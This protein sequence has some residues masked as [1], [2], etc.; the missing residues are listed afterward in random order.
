MRSTLERKLTLGYL[1]SLKK[2]Y[3]KGKKVKMRHTYGQGL[4]FW[5]D[6]N[7]DNGFILGFYEEDLASFLASNIQSGSVF[8]DLGAHWGYFSLLASKLVGDK[9]RVYAFEP[10]PRNFR[11]LQKNLEINSTQQIELFNLAV[12]EKIGK[13]RFSNTDD[14]FANT[15]V[16]N[17]SGNLLEICAINLD[18]FIEKEGILPPDFIKID[19]EGAELDVLKG[20]KETIVHFRPKIHL[21][22]HDV[23]VPGIDN[24]CRKWMKEVGYRME[25]LS[26]KKRIADYICISE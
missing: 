5:L 14:S 22:T 4:Y 1:E 25:K 20:A 15:Y 24:E 11:H 8:Y 7:T 2:V 16:T 17:S 19:V 6:A 3:P 10:M 26:S 13:V 23:H 9:G 12:S 21:S 18:S